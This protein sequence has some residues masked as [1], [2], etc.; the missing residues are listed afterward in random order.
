MPYDGPSAFKTIRVATIPGN[1]SDVK[2]DA[3]ATVGDALRAAGVNPNGMSIRVD[4]SPASLTDP[5]TDKSSILVAPAIRGNYGD[6]D[7]VKTETHTVRVSQI[8]GGI[9]DIK[10]PSGTTVRD[11]IAKA[12]METSGMTIRMNGNNVSLDEKITGDFQITMSRAIR[13][14]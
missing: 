10:V 12:G 14:N 9:L 3:S 4:N 6:N 11:A 13:G 1:V 2:V 8:P 7:D 5:V